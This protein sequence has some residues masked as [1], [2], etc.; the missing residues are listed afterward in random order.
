MKTLIKVSVILASILSANEFNLQKDWNLKGTSYEFNTKNIES[1]CFDGF[2]LYSDSWNY[3]KT[4][5]ENIID[6]DSGFWIK[7]K[8]D[9]NFSISFDNEELNNKL[10]VTKGWNLIGTTKQKWISDI[11]RENFS[12]VWYYDRE[13]ESWSNFLKQKNSSFLLAKNSGV[14]INSKKDLELDYLSLDSKSDALNGKLLIDNEIWDSAVVTVDYLR[15]EGDSDAD[16]N[17]IVKGVDKTKE[18]LYLTA[19][20]D[21]YK[22]FKANVKSDF[23]SGVTLCESETREANNLN[24]GAPIIDYNGTCS[25]GIVDITGQSYTNEYGKTQ[26]VLFLLDRSGSTERVFE[27]SDS[28]L[29]VELDIVQSLYQSLNSGKND[30]AFVKFSRFF[31]EDKVDIE[32]DSNISYSEIDDYN[33]SKRDS[34]Y[35]SK[36]VLFNYDNNT[37]IDNLTYSLGNGDKTDIT[38]KGGTDTGNAIKISLSEFD[39]SKGDHKSIIL[40][41]DGIPTLPFGSGHVPSSSDFGYTA[42]QSQQATNS[43]INIYPFFLHNQNYHNSGYYE[44]EKDLTWNQVLGIIQAIGDHEVKSYSS[45]NSIESDL[46]DFNIVGLSSFKIYKNEVSQENELN[47]TFSA[48]GSFSLNSEYIDNLDKII[49]VS[50]AGE[51]TTKELSCKTEVENDINFVLKS[52]NKSAIS[53]IVFYLK[54]ANA[55]IKKVKIEEFP[56]IKEV[57]VENFLTTHYLSEYDFVAYTLKAGNNKSGMGPGEGE[58]FIVDESVAE[59]DLPTTSVDCETTHSNAIEKNLI[60]AIN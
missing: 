19:I 51:S 53:N 28:V 10:S 41:T 37:S 4:D 55:D 33:D 21:G 12:Y 23:S 2:W 43:N 45:T 34:N 58:L 32:E 18:C 39:F 30:F 56:E 40:L 17:F 8:E 44:D 36:V 3:I 27:T 46:K 38:S 60:C 31:D 5:S 59:A 48:D 16:G 6:K 1:Q 47:H 9:C 11:D 24:L 49:I 20:K 26:S 29:K 35:T 22:P 14:W 52:P 7:A 50:E 42:Y 13:K 54:D 15:A 57:D 25:S